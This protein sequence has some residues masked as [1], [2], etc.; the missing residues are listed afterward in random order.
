MASRTVWREP[1]ERQSKWLRKFYA[2]GGMTA[3]A[4]RRD[5]G[6]V[7]LLSEMR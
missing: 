5:A 3:L 1:T 6:A 4:A 7:K 2:A